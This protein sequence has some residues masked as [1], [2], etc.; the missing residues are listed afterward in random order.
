MT[1][2]RKL[3]ERCARVAGFGSP[4]TGATC[5]TGSEHPKGSG[6]NGALWNYVGH[7]DTA[8][9]W[10][11][12]TS[13]ADAA[14]MAI[15]CKVDVMWKADHGEGITGVE[16]WAWNPDGIRAITELKD[17]PTEQA[18]YCYAVCSVVAQMGGE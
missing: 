17:H 11:P 3:L 7:M 15:K 14:D 4:G 16:A 10:N 1:D 9:L 18:A 13:V 12:L 6:R 8:Q 5:W 2:T